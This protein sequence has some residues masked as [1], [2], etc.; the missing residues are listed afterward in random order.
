M[1]LDTFLN[2][3]LD[4]TIRSDTF[5][6]L[7]N[8]I[9]Q[10]EEG[11]VRFY[12]KPETLCPR[13]WQASNEALITEHGRPDQPLSISQHLFGGDHNVSARL[14]YDPPRDAGQRGLE[15]HSHPV[16]TVIFVVSGTGQY[17]F[18]RDPD[19]N[20][21]ITVDLA[22]GAVLFFPASTV[23][24]IVEVGK[25]GLETLNATDRLN[26]PQYRDAKTTSVPIPSSVDFSE[27]HL[28]SPLKTIAYAHYLHLERNSR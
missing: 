11:F 16:D 18:V 7:V 6:R 27:T 5:S 24:T 3:I 13:L 9:W 12:S 15:Y 21:A 10:S 14:V 1:D 20:E 8:K 19:S 23:H 2:S 26:Q 22:A 17:A 4:E 28:H 25:D